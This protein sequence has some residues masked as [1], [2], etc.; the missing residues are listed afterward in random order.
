MSRRRRKK[1][2]MSIVVPIASMGDIAFLVLIFFILCSEAITEKPIPNLELASSVDVEQLKERG[3]I[4]IAIDAKGQTHMSWGYE[5]TILVQDTD[6]IKAAVEARIAELKQHRTTLRPQDRYV[7]F[8]C[9]RT[10]DQTLYQPV[11]NAIAE[12]GGVI[13][14]TG[15]K[16]S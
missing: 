4:F 2:G 1:R 6:Q 16:S 9:D 11:I 14:N 8:K 7:L 13:L 12:G 15:I 10:V 3:G 5:K